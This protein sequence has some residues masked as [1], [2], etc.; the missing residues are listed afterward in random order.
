MLPFNL[1]RALAVI[2]LCSALSAT[3]TASAQ[4]VDIGQLQR[5]PAVQAAVSAC[6]ADR[7][8]LCG[9]VTPGGGRI[10]RCLA[11]NPD[12]LSPPCRA[13]MEKASSELGPAGAALMPIRPAR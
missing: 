5:S 3:N 12:A 10:V 1:S 4:N 6:K 11:A 2:A 9:G 13:A 8:Q 7:A